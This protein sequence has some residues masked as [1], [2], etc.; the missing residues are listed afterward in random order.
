MRTILVNLPHSPY[1]IWVGRRLLERLPEFLGRLGLTGRIFLV[2][3]RNVARYHLARFAAALRKAKRPHEVFYLPEGERAKS[4]KVLLQIYRALAKGRFE[5]RDPLIA[6]GG[7]AV[8]D[9]AGFA[10]STYL[11]GIPLVQVGTT[12][13]AQVDS[14]IGGKTGM[15]L[16][17]GKNLVGSFYQPRLV[18]SDVSLL[19]TLARRDL[20]ASL[21]EVIKCG[22]IRDGKLF[23]YLEENLD[24]I[25]AGNLA[26]LEEI[27]FRSARIKAEIVERDEKETRG[28]RMVLNYGHTFGHAFEAAKNYRG[29]RHGEAVA[30]GMAAAAHLARKRQMLPAADE[31]RQNRLIERAGLPIRLR[32]YRL[33]EERVIRH[34]LLDKKKKGGRLRFI[35]PEA[36]G[37]VRVVDDVSLAEVK[38]VLEELGGK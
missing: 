24:S 6:L 22:V 35:L 4:A 5:R 32:P 16:P 34:M 2:T 20:V 19:S 10:A 37:G 27:V 30:L 33:D 18:V 8:G 25:L 29:L 28:E 31:I 7:G 38:E 13:L 15:N 26:R 23:G 14:S 17:E 9:V 11:R 3:E 21:A 36:I 12:L 1:R